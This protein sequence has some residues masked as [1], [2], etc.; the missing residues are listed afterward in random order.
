MR[1]ISNTITFSGQ[2]K[3]AQIDP[4]NENLRQTYKISNQHCATTQ[5]EYGLFL[6]DYQRAAKK[7]DK[8]YKRQQQFLSAA[9]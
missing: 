4:V 2:H 7:R 5:Q 1:D 9:H 6:K 3:K 8:I